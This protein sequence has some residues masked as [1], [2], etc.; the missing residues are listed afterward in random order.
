[1]IARV[2]QLATL[3]LIFAALAW[4]LFF[5]VQGAF[6]VAACGTLLILL[7]YALFLGLEFLLLA[8]FGADLSVGRPSPAQLMSAWASE[9]LRAPLIFCW[10]QPFRSQSESDLTTALQPAQ[11][12]VIFVHGFFCNRGFWN[13][14]MKTLRERGVPF[15]AVNLEPPFGSIGGYAGIIESAV[16]RIE[17]ATRHPPVIVAHSMGGLAV[18]AWLA[19]RARGHRPHRVITI[20]SPHWG[21]RLARFARTVNGLEMRSSSTW[22][23][24]LASG[25]TLADRARFTCFYG[26]CD[27]IVFPASAATLSGADN[28]HLPGTAHVQMAFHREVMRELLR[29]LQPVP[30]LDPA[31]GT[32]A[33]AMESQRGSYSPGVQ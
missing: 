19:G 25:E 11:R 12:G 32:L 21:T 6:A 20:G 2:Q 8:F 16:E 33:G 24:L 22:I 1:M 23:D 18:R 4:A 26:N 13:P 9:V 30:L 27:N 15:I 31:G 10:R 28:R 29:W 3:T 7:G 14:W 5:G 17:A